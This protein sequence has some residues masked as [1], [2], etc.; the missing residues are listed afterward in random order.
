METKQKQ[1]I[2]ISNQRYGSEKNNEP[3]EYSVDTDSERIEKLA[4]AFHIDK[5]QKYEVNQSGEDLTSSSSYDLPKGWDAEN[6]AAAKVVVEII[7][8]FEGVIDL[9]DEED[10]NAVGQRIHSEWLSRNEWAK[11]SDLD[12]DFKDLPADEQYNY[13]TQITTAH[14]VLAA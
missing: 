3:G 7:N 6:R 8:D 13:V 4:E 11:G 2:D 10:I 5:L 14:Q 12:V 9:K 1:T